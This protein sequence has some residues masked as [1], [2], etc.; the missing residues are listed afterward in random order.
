MNIHGQKPSHFLPTE[1]ASAGYCFFS[2]DLHLEYVNSAAVRLSGNQSAGEL[3]GRHLHEFVIEDYPSQYAGLLKRVLEGETIVWPEVHFR[4]G[5]A[6]TGSH[7]IILHPFV[8]NTSILG[9]E[10][11]IGA[12][13][14]RPARTQ[15]ED[16]C[17]GTEARLR[18]RT[19]ELE[20]ANKKLRAEID[21]RKQ[22]EH[23]AWESQQ[24]LQTFMEHSL[25]GLCIVE[26]NL[27][28]GKKRLVACNDQYVSMSGRSR[29]E[30][31]ATE[32]LNDFLE[33]KATC[34]ELREWNNN[35]R[36]G[37][38]FK[39]EATWK[40]P[41][42]SRT[43]IE[44]T[45]APVRIG[46]KTYMFGIDRDVTKRKQ[47]EEALA[48]ERN[49]LRAVVDNIPDAIFVKDDQHRFVFCNQY[50]AGYVGAADA[51][52]M[53]GKTDFEYF[54]AERARYFHQ[55]EAR[56]LRQGAAMIGREEFNYNSSGKERW[57]L[58]TKAPWR[59]SEGRI[60][61]LVGINREITNLKQTQIELRKHRDQ[62]EQMI[63]E[64]TAELTRANEKLQQEIEE[65]KRA[66]GSLRRSEQRFREFVEGTDNLV[67][68]EGPDLHYTYVNKAAARIFGLLPEECIGRPI[69]DFIPE[70]DH[71]GIRQA[72]RD[73]VKEKRPNVT[74]ENKVYDANGD[75]RTILWTI[76]FHYMNGEDG[77]FVNAIGRDITER[78]RMEEQIRRHNEELE[79]LVAERSEQLLRAARLSAV[80]RLVAG[81]AH[82]VNNPLQGILSHMGLIEAGLDDPEVLESARMVR[83]AVKR[84]AG[85]VGQL[86]EL[87][88]SYG[89][90]NVP[91]DV[92]TTVEETVKLS[93]ATF[94]ERNIIMAC[95]YGRNLSHAYG[96][97]SGLHQALVN[98]I[99]NAQDAMPEGG[100]LNIST[101]ED[102][103]Y[104]TI[105]VRDAGTG[106]DEDILPQIFEPFVTSK[107]PGEGTGLGLAITRS[108]IAEMG[109]YIKAENMPDGGA[110]FI[111][112]L[113][114]I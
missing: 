112:G 35:I 63:A 32:D 37:I 57:A 33:F 60:I 64:R 19:E 6:G 75:A 9:L 110:Q 23:A 74:Y 16:A 86:K 17:T 91:F 67:V 102:S 43:Y 8:K 42:G 22:A 41:D 13:A 53:Y 31:M 107:L 44:W 90:R 45:A 39:G 99:I 58:N 66:T 10:M 7:T 109:G 29:D 104:V 5:E 84:I 47:A 26:Q 113:K 98:L 46:D 30:L 52:S 18:Q 94:K 24:R 73:C 61:G 12:N 51:E 92:N 77:A 105:I 69:F 14:Q 55:E 106:V 103:E 111:I 96:S 95:H 93:R 114:K 36:N 56:I 68:Q 20:R 80:G 2:P 76:N 71:E 72:Y 4:N 15:H 81:V 54:T 1:S 11:F 28:T 82:E 88:K 89:H 78:I 79:Q 70:T 48:N 108:A 27:N 21:R 62:L 97:V 101:Q 50:C 49:L 83:Q 3:L 34:E 87:Y 59:D 38:P 85:V 40:R 65:R 25:D 100:R